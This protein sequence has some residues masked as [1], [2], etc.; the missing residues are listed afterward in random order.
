M[1][2]GI[3]SCFTPYTEW[4]RT[5]YCFA[6]CVCS[7]NEINHPFFQDIKPAL[8]TLKIYFKKVFNT[9]SCVQA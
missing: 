3:M 6:L 7:L 4:H 8:F 2:L 9:K 1:N 5:S